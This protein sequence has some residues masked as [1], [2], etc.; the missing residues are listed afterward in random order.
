ML[1]QMVRAA[2]LDRR[3]FTELIFDNYAT[4]NAV[5]VVAATYA[6]IALTFAL[7]RPLQLSLIGLLRLVLG[8]LVG[9]LVLGGAL[10]VVGVKLFNGRGR[11]Q[12]ILR[13]I[14]F[15]HAPL[16]VCAVGLLLPA[17]LDTVV[18]A[19][20]F[21]WFFAAVASATRVLFDFDLSHAAS[22]TLLAFAVWWVAS[23]IG[24]GLNITTILGL[25]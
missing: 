17:S 19:V 20:G 1:R 4:G 25:G 2:R 16:V 22:T 10:W 24:L 9:W 5:M 14:G 7:G 15:A 8:G 18:V 23:L 11:G 12:T 3:F 6:L 13:L 21:L